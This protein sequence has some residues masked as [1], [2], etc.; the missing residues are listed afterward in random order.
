MALEQLNEYRV[1]TSEE[2]EQ[3]ICAASLSAAATALE[4]GTVKLD[5]VTI[6]DWV[7]ELPIEGGEAVD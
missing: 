7:N 5:Q 6:S 4:V 2:V 1:I 3:V